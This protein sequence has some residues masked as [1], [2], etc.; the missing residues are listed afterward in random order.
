MCQIAAHLRLVSI[1]GSTVTSLHLVISAPKPLHCGRLCAL[2]LHSWLKRIQCEAVFLTGGN[3]LYLPSFQ[4][5]RQCQAQLGFS[6]KASAMPASIGDEESLSG[7][8]SRPRF[9][10]NLELRSREGSRPMHVFN[11]E[12]RG[13]NLFVHQY[14]ARILGH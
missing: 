2:P 10:L 11:V 9:S 1:T 8:G 12:A 14:G 5:C 7:G 4:A 13:S 3:D 6:R